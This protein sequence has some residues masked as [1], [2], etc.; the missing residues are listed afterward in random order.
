[1]TCERR[2]KGVRQG[3]G[4]AA[5]GGA[6]AAGG[7]GGGGGS[8]G[9]AGG[10]APYVR[11][12]ARRRYVS[13]SPGR[14]RRAAQSPAEPSRAE[15]GRAARRAEGRAGEGRGG[16]ARPGLAGRRRPLLRR[17]SPRRMAGGRAAAS[18]PRGLPPAGSRRL[19]PLA[20]SP[21]AGGRGEPRGRDKS[22]PGGIPGKKGSPVF[23]LL[24]SALVK[25]CREVFCFLNMVI[26]GIQ[27]LRRRSR[28]FI[29]ATPKY[30]FAL[31]SP[32]YS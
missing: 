19:P 7:G 24:G 26:A 23:A 30:P 18:R 13:G 12:A 25:R 22:A 29:P 9:S 3:L 14:Q 21:R 8:A 2:R 6:A 15:P 28:S 31:S 17:G 27:L 1:M 16:E 4:S 10:T 5:A 32:K 11:R 20:L